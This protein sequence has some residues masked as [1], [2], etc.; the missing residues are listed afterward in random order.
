ME[1]VSGYGDETGITLLVKKGESEK[2]VAIGQEFYPPDHPDFA[3][4]VETLDSLPPPTPVDPDVLLAEEIRSQRNDLLAASDWTQVADAPV[5]QSAWA[6]YRQALRD[7]PQQSG[8][9]NNV[10]WPEG[11]K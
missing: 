6:T 4:A 2:G 7:I 1:I 11:P 8:F 5:D 9:P 3:W 10:T